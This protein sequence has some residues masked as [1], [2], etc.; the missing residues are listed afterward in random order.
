VPRLCAAAR[1]LKGDITPH[2]N[3]ARIAELLKHRGYRFSAKSL[4][5]GTLRISWYHVSKDARPARAN[6]TALTVGTGTARFATAGT[7]KITIKLTRRG[8]R[9]LK[10]AK[11]I[12]ITARGSFTR[13]R[14]TLA[15]STFILLLTEHKARPRSQRHAP[16][17]R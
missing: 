13:A 16:E 5:A 3:A 2:G 14:A 4:T 15:T 11:R 12:K 17:R 10:H 6:P 8:E 9:L 7:A 1:W